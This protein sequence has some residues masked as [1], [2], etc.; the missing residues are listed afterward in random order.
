[1]Y[2]YIYVER[3]GASKIFILSYPF[4][5][6]SIFM[7]IG[8]PHIRTFPPGKCW[9]MAVRVFP[10]KLWAWCWGNSSGS[11]SVLPPYGPELSGIG[12]GEFPRKD[13]GLECQMRLFPSI[14]LYFFSVN[15]WWLEWQDVMPVWA[16]HQFLLPF[17]IFCSIVWVG[18]DDP[19]TRDKCNF[20]REAPLQG[21]WVLGNSR[22]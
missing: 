10:W 12:S 3:E 19:P 7:S 21:E 1:M 14:F 8:D 2:I 15:F 20:G 6:G 18:E 9:S 22:N 17:H 16:G 4:L 13:E 5:S 11:A